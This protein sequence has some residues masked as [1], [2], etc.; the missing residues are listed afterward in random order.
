MDTEIEELVR[1]CEQC[2]LAAKNPIKTNLS[3][4][5]EETEPWHRVHIDFAGP[6][7]GQYFLLVVDAYSKWPEISTISNITSFLTLEILERHFC[8]FG[9]P[10]ILV[11]D[12][13]TQ[14]TSAAFREFC[15]KRGIKHIRTPPYHPQ[16]NGQVERFV[17]TFKRTVTKIGGRNLMVALSTFLRT[18]RATLGPSGK[19]PAK[20]FLRRNIRTEISLL[21][22][23]SN[24]NSGKN[25]SKNTRDMQYQFD[26]HHGARPKFFNK[27]EAVF[28]GQYFGNNQNWSPATIIRNRGRVMYVIRDKNGKVHIRHA[29]QMK[30]RHDNF[31]PLVPFKENV[32]DAELGQE[33]REETGVEPKQPTDQRKEPLVKEPRYPRRIRNSPKRFNIGNCKGKTYC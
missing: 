3:P 32:Q 9:L 33:G 7:K 29:N 16:S 5:A 11:S 21:R 25:L 20:L 22:P 13:G 12:N 14:I 23:E 10:K 15:E 6:F 1:Q 31:G 17:D 4:W 30:L 27:G 24:K 8:R 19:T 2:A 26:K 18:Y 28:F